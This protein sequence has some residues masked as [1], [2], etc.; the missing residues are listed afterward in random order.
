MKRAQWK[1]VIFAVAAGGLNLFGIGCWVVQP[2]L[3]EP[4]ISIRTT[5]AASQVPEIR[6]VSVRTADPC[7]AGSR[8]TGSESVPSGEPGR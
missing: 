2:H 4:G 8:A 1:L 7:P 3:S 6:G 5:V